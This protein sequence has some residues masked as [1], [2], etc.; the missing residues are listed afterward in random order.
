MNSEIVIAGSIAKTGIS[1][2]I[3]PPES[4]PGRRHPGKGLLNW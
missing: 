2:H 1:A 3:L 4:I